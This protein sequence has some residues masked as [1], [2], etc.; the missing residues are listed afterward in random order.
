MP[1]K[2]LR[3]FFAGISTLSPGPP[4]DSKEKMP[5]KS[6]V[7]MA[8]NR[9]KPNDDGNQP[10]EPH[11]V[12][13]FVPRSIIAEPVQPDAVVQN[14]KLGECW[15]YFIDHA[16]VALDRRPSIGITYYIERE[17]ALAERPG[18]D[19][20]ASEY[21]IRWL[22]DLR[23]VVDDA[24]INEPSVHVGEDVAVV[25]ELT[26]GQWKA[27][28]PCKSALPMTFKDADQNVIKI[29]DDA[30]NEKPLKRVFANEFF[31]EMPFPA[32]VDKITLRLTPLRQDTPAAGLGA[33]KELVL[34]WGN[35]AVIDVHMGNDT[36]DEASLVS[37][38]QRCDARFFRSK[39]EKPV[40][41]ERDEDFVL[42]Y[43]V[44]N[45][46]GDKRPLPHNGPQQTHFNGCVPANGG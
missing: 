4:R 22:A 20:V 45:V 35:N 25:I 31:I 14:D 8:A 6:F 28:F 11:S 41:V 21:D 44:L 13:I 3:M 18:S 29:K 12:Y 19:D 10:I 37:S 15:V 30:G 38:T 1:E 33:S 36:K 42:H 5:D 43:K 7:L 2:M 9:K 32:T 46:K 24:S 39:N 16:R 26:G 23:Q 40:V 27:S 34:Q 17:K